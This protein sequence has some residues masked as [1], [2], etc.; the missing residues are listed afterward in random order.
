MDISHPYVWTQREA[1]NSRV[2]SELAEVKDLV[3]TN[4]NFWKT[5]QKLEAGYK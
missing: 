4:S 1:K 5:D 3:R 2:N